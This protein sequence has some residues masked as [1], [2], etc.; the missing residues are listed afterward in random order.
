MLAG[1]MLAACRT[2]KTVLVEVKDNGDIVRVD[3]LINK[4]VGNTQSDY[5]QYDTRLPELH[6]AKLITPA[7]NYNPTDMA[8]FPVYGDPHWVSDPGSDSMEDC[9][10]L[11][12]TPEKTILC[13]VSRLY[14]DRHYF[15]LKSGTYIRDC[16]TDK[17]YYVQNHCGYPLDQTYFIDG[18]T[19]GWICMSSEFPPLPPT[20]T[21]IDIFEPDV[22][23]NV[24]GTPGWSGGL[25]LFEVPVERL[26][27]NQF[28]TE[29][30][31]IKVIK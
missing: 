15:Q 8:T 4:L 16:V 14:W 28:I 3:K 23:E 17:K 18:V 31:K 20:C 24:E 1:I 6:E 27:H 5:I 29:Y 10:A 22:N 19:G 26:Q 11:Y 13:S 2:P 25:K 7:N 9:V 12:C 21:V 30:K